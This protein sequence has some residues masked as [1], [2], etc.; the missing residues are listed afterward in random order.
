[1]IR[2]CAW[3]AAKA[4][5]RPIAAMT[6]GKN[7][8][9]AL[10]ALKA[11]SARSRFQPQRA[12]NGLYPGLKKRRSGT[13]EPQRGQVMLAMIRILMEPFVRPTGSCDPFALIGNS[14]GFV[15]RQR[16]LW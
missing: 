16:F 4:A 5:K 15:E 9:T 1:M 7:F 8:I 6:S 12:Q 13:C 2:E 14:F 11:A 3:M 10:F